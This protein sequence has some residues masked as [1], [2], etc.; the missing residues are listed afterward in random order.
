MKPISAKK[1]PDWVSMLTLEQLGRRCLWTFIGAIAAAVGIVIAKFSYALIPLVFVPW[2]VLYWMLFR[3][4]AVLRQRIFDFGEFI[5]PHCMYELVD[6]R[7]HLRCFECGFHC[8]PAELHPL[9]EMKFRGD[10][11][12]PQTPF[13]Q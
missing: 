3:Y 6:K 4:R 2:A 5:C 9:W 10:R 13:R 12:N 8:Q 11:R 1:L 7:D